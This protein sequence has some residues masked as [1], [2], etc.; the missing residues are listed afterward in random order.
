MK[1]TELWLK[2][3]SAC[4]DGIKWFK[5]QKETEAIPVLRALLKD[6][7]FQ[8]ANWAICRIMTK[9]HCVRYAIFAALEVLFIYEKKYPYDKR[10]RQ[11]IEAAQK[12][13]DNPTSNAAADAADAAAADAAAAAATAADAYAAYA[14]DAA[15]RKKLQIKILEY[16]I[17]L[18]KGESQ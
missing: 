6:Q 14:A 17:S 15:A 11:A 16:G 9:P 2:E 18:L 13:L 7:K 3:K 10:P 4:F 8:W 1:I 12:W 5:A